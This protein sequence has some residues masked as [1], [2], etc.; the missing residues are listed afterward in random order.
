MREY[1]EIVFSSIIFCRH[2]FKL[3]S[4]VFDK[5]I[6]TETKVIAL[7]LKS[8]KYDWL[9]KPN[10]F[11]QDLYNFALVT[12]HVESLE[13]EVARIE[14]TIKSISDIKSSQVSGCF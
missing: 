2:A 3:H 1:Q 7:Q 13:G 4:N 6:D 10:I 12:D 14:E 5:G 11:S 9:T 8:L